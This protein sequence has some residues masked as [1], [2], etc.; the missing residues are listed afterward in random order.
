[1]KVTKACAHLQRNITQPQRGGGPAIGDNT[2]ELGDIVL[3]ETRQTDT[4]TVRFRYVWDLKKRKREE[5]SK[6][7]TLLDTENRFMVARGREW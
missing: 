5:T 6:Q 7:K 4:N 3:R 1:M 2:M